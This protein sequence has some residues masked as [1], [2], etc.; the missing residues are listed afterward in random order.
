MWPLFLL[1]QRDGQSPNTKIN[2]LVTKYFQILKRLP[3]QVVLYDWATISAYI[4]PLLTTGLEPKNWQWRLLDRVIGMLQ[5]LRP[6][7]W[8]ELLGELDRY[9]SLGDSRTV[10]LTKRDCGWSHPC[11]RWLRRE[12]DLWWEQSPT[13]G[14]GWQRCM[15][16]L[17]HKWGYFKRLPGGVDCQQE[18][19]M[20][21]TKRR[22]VRRD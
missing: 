3:K 14:R 21:E 13:P 8:G 6:C 19:L 20:E 10:T 9:G 15:F 17:D 5:D 12:R 22:S 1:P 16:P 11:L 7:P 2:T 4:S 18:G